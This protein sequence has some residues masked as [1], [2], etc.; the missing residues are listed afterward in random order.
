MVGFND[1]YYKTWRVM[2]S[3][4][5]SV[6]LCLCLHTCA[7]FCNKRLFNT[8]VTPGTAQLKSNTLQESITCWFYWQRTE[9]KWPT[10]KGRG[11]LFEE[12]SN[13][14]MENMI[15]EV[16]LPAN[17]DILWMQWQ[18]ATVKTAVSSASQ[19]FKRYI[20]RWKFLRGESSCSLSEAM[21][22]RWY[23]GMT[24]K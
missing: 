18:A 15:T 9:L 19:I 2:Q 5:E 3:A 23:D 16:A 1:T 24:L 22:H 4:F 11:V 6:Y 13:K 21:K 14:M 20:H 12:H 7:Y 8:C 10:E 17:V